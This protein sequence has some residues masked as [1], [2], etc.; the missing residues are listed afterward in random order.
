VSLGVD[1]NEATEGP[2]SAYID[3]TYRLGKW[4]SAAVSSSHEPTFIPR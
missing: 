2:V 1:A 4:H 3:N